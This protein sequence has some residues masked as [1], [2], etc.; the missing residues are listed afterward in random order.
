MTARTG[1]P[2]KNNQE[3]GEKRQ[4]MTARSGSAI[5]GQLWHD[6]CDRKTMTEQSLDK[7]AM[8]RKSEMDCHSSAVVPGGTWQIVMTE[9]S[10]HDSQ[11]E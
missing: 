5:T 8:R 9:N 11:T 7:P 1:E 2:K 3:L 4:N 10:E 6:Y